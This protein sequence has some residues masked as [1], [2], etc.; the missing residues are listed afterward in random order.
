MRLAGGP[1]I[2]AVAVPAGARHAEHVVAI[3]VGARI[4]HLLLREHIL[5]HDARLA[6]L[7]VDEA[8]V[9]A[10]EHGDHHRRLRG[11]H[12]VHVQV[13]L[14]AVAP[15]GEAGLLLLGIH[16][17]EDVVVGCAHGEIEVLR[18]AEGI[19]ALVVAGA[20]HIVPAHAVVALAAEVE[21]LPIGVHEGEVL[22]LVG[23]DV[24]GELHRRGEGAV[25]QQLGAVDVL[26]GGA[27]LAV[28]AEVDGALAF[29]QVHHRALLLLLVE[30]GPELLGQ[31]HDLA[32]DVGE[33]VEA[34]EFGIGHL[35]L[36]AHGDLLQA[37]E[38]LLAI[39]A[40]ALQGIHRPLGQQLLVGGAE[41]ALVGHHGILEAV[42]EVIGPA[43]PVPGHGV[44]VGRIGGEAQVADGGLLVGAA[45][46]QAGA[47]AV[48]EVA[49][50]GREAHQLRVKGHGLGEALLQEEL[51]GLSTHLLIAALGLGQAGDQ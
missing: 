37:A 36:A 46:E 13:A 33:V 29:G 4:G 20:E 41:E 24:A 15:A 30:A 14:P 21:G 9:G 49:V 22:V 17:V 8:G 27:V 26:A 43:Q 11:A 5:H 40:L 18:A 6:V 35:H 2:D 45:E 34:E 47:E 42:V 31:H 44:G 25:G 50:A 51:V 12:A 23:V 39:A 1:A 16:D 19:E 10:L 32:T 48:V 38:E 28:A 3:D 7:L